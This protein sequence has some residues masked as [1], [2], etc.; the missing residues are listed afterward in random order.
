MTIQLHIAGAPG[1]TMLQIFPL[2]PINVLPA[3]V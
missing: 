2:L 3:R 1:A